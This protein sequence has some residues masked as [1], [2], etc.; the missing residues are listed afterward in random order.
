MTAATFSKSETMIVAAA[1][2]AVEPVTFTAVLGSGLAGALAPVRFD[3]TRIETDS[4]QVERRGFHTGRIGPVLRCSERGAF[5]AVRA[6][7]GT[8]RAR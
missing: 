3:T 8:G 4:G 6:A 2:T 5:H 1:V 7:F